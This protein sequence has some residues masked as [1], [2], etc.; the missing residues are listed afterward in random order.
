[1]CRCLSWREDAGECPL[2][3]AQIRRV[4]SS[5]RVDDTPHTCWRRSPWAQSLRARESATS[6]RGQK[7]CE[8]RP[9]RLRDHSTGPGSGQTP[10]GSRYRGPCGHRRRDSNRQER[11]RESRADR[12]SRSKQPSDQVYLVRQ[13][14]ALEYQVGALSMAHLEQVG[15]LCDRCHGSQRFLPLSMVWT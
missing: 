4:H 7:G 15:S 8:T 11:R 12:E 10:A 6:C 2:H 13:S 9:H 1:M 5:H 14:R 3:Q